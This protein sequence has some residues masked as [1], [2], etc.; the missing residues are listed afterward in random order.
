[1][2]LTWLEPAPRGLHN[3]AASGAPL[4]RL[5]TVPGTGAA[6]GSRPTAFLRRRPPIAIRNHPA[7]ATLRPCGRGGGRCGHSFRC[8]IGRCWKVCKTQQGGDRC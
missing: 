6:P 4:S 7:P 3:T 5:H 1:M 8:A 2:S